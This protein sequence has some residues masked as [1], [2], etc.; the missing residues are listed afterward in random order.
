MKLKHI[1]IKDELIKIKRH[2]RIKLFTLIWSENYKQDEQN[3][4]TKNQNQG[5]SV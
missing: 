3:D 5:Y 2:D 1:Y 4:R